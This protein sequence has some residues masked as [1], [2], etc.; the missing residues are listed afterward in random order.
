MEWNIAAECIS[1]VVLCILWIY[2]RKGNPIPS[3]KNKLFQLCFL[4]TFCAMVS[5]I[6]STILIYTLNP[7][8]LLLTWILNTFYFIATP[9]MGTVYFFY[10]LANVYEGNPKISKYFL[11]TSLPSIVY[12]VMVLLNPLTRNIFNITL[13][14][15]YTQEKLIMTTYYVF[16]FYCIACVVLIILQGKRVSTA[17]KVILFT[18]PL[19]AVIVIL[20]QMMYPNI[21]LSGSAATCA[22]LLIYLYLQN[23]QLSIDHLTNIPNRQE[24]LK[25]LEIALKKEANFTLLVLSL[26][27][28][29]SVNDHYGQHIGDALL[30]AVSDFLRKGMLLREGILYRYSGDEFAIL[31]KPRDQRSVEELV[32]QIQARMTLPWEVKGCTCLLS[33]GIGVVQY[34]QVAK[35]MEGLTNGIECAVSIAKRG[36]E[37]QYV[38]YCTPAI[39]EQANRRQKI[40]E[41]L[42]KSIREDCFILHYQPILNVETKRFCKAEAL[43]R[44]YD[45]ELGN[46]SP[47]EFI[48]IAEESGMI[49]EITYVVLD[50][51]CRFIRHLMD[52]DLDFD[53]ISVNFSAFQFQQPDLMERMTEIINAYG[54]PFSKVRVEITE[55]VLA[56][57]VS[58]ITDYMN[59]MHELGIRIGL[60]DFGTGYSNLTAVLDLPIDTVKLDKSLVWASM[61]NNR[62]SI[63][64]QNFTR[65]FR[66]LEISV[67]AEGVENVEQSRFVIDCGCGFIQGFFYAKPMPEDEVESYLR[68]LVTV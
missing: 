43:L 44:L 56:Q 2:S 27:E 31:I 28:F 35:D 16:Y 57:S 52:H 66:E 61:K 10:S 58:V 12:G 25:M 18:Y 24:F 46:I 11:I 33:A 50:K 40:V 48:P 39:L 68:Q 60:D 19:I 54:I 29:K 23:K 4:V 67:L 41:I 37:Q 5:N 64:V 26:R 42:K 63:V 30:K 1:T 34:P 65:A 20:I 55:S 32:D 13:E 53:G 51:V 15:G 17:I 59:R 49:V 8:T 9:L 7:Y 21:I 62:F 38:C 22:I 3:L 36:G 45:E 14:H 47:G 6:L